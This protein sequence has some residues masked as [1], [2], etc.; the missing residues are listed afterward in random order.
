M[1]KSEIIAIFFAERL[2]D[3]LVKNAGTVGSSDPSFSKTEK[4]RG[5]GEHSLTSIQR[6]HFKYTIIR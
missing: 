2:S 5:Y 1:M 6:F 3:T 4:G